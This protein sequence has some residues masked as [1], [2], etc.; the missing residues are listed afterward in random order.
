MFLIVFAW[1]PWMDRDSNYALVTDQYSVIGTDEGGTG[2]DYQVKWA[3]FG[4]WVV[5]CEEGHYVLFLG[6]LLF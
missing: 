4:R 3:P 5:N 1:A 6:I 2:C